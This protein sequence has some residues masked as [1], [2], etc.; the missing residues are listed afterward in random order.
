MTRAVVG[1]LVLKDLERNQGAVRMPGHS[2]RIQYQ[3]LDRAIAEST[4]VD[5]Y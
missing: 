2:H 3:P 1:R 5:G 4:R